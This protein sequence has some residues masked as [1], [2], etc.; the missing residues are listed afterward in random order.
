MKTIKQNKEFEEVVRKVA[1]MEVE[2]NFLKTCI[3]NL[4]NAFDR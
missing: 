2:I 1:E 4:N 3:N